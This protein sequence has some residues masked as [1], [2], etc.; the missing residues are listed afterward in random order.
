MIVLSWDVGI[1]N[2]AYCLLSY[3]NDNWK[4]ID[5]GNVD[6]LGKNKD[7][8]GCGARP[9]LYYQ[10]I[11]IERNFYCK[12]CAKKLEINI[13]TFE[14]NFKLDNTNVCC[15]ENRKSKKKCGKKSKFINSTNC[16]CNSH[17][18]SIYKQLSN[19][20][21]LKDYKKINASKTSI[22]II[23][24]RLVKFLDTKKNL[25]QADLVVIE[26]QPT[27]KNPKMKAVSSTIYDYYLIRGIIDKEINKS[28]IQF[29]KYMSPSNK[30]KLADNNSLIKIKKE[31]DSSKQYKLT[32]HLAILYCS[33]MITHMPEW[34]SHFEKQK[35]KDDLADC[36][37]QGVYYYTK[38]ILK[39]ID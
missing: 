12:R 20:Y 7:T 28:N 15:W 34:A 1:I 10:P 19:S 23:R 25:L 16:Y 38:N 24:P 27:L 9:K 14:N 2:L 32:K 4:I 6:L 30:I 17:A 33:K 3:E 36:F 35:K 22:D 31:K 26:N 18:K 8:C 11:G 5:W 21:S 39:K 29:V 37:L 13:P